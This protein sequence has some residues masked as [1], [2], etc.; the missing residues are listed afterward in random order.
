M[1]SHAE[2]LKA[3]TGV[4]NLG[5]KRF[6]AAVGLAVILHE[7][8][9]PDF[10][11]LRMVFVHKLATRDFLTLLGRT[12]VDMDLRAGAAGACIAHFPKVV[13]LVAVD[14][15][16]GRKMFAPYRLGFIVAFETFGCAALE[17]GGIEVCRIEM[18][19]IYK[20]FPCHVDG[21][22]LEIVA[23]RPVAEHFEHSMVI[24]VMAY[25]LKVVVLAAH[26]EALLRVGH[27]AALGGGVAKDD[28]L[29]LVHARVGKHQRGVVFD[30]HR[31]GRHDMM[32]FR[33]KIVFE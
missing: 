27:A 5:G 20:I 30:Y 2:A 24:S 32:A 28:V 8:E 14:D 1:K 13:V 10:D 26:T 7:H 15:M 3:H 21:A 9:V 25:F 17:Y 6:E 33:L 23:E 29:E 16:V 18:K 19:N 22:L 4:D 12:K 11:N 31:C